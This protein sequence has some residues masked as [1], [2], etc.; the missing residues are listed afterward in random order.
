MEKQEVPTIF[1]LFQTTDYTFLQLDSGVGGNKIVEEYEANGVVKLRDGMVQ[2]DN[3]EAF[4]STST[5][6]IRPSE[7]FVATLGG[8]MVGHGVRVEK[9]NHEPENYRII[10]QVEGYDFDLGQLDFYRVTLKR[11]SIWAESDLP[12]Q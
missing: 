5:V 9:D 12:L 11:E 6:H 1:D 7:P 3:V 8:N 10:G 4:E 2:E